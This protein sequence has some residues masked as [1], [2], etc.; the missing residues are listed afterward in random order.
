ML[1]LFLV[2]SLVRSVFPFNYGSKILLFTDWFCFDETD[3]LISCEKAF[4]EASKASGKSTMQRCILLYLDFSDEEIWTKWSSSRKQQYIRSQIERL[5]L[6]NDE[7]RL[8]V[9]RSLTYI[10]LGCFGEYDDEHALQDS[11]YANAKLLLD[12]GIIPVVIQAFHRELGKFPG[13][14]GLL[15][16]I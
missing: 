16:L 1:P 13:N 2:K 9:Y 12:D 3:D 6:S 7:A 11:I 4:M 10:A 8:N 5:D 14:C 15:Q